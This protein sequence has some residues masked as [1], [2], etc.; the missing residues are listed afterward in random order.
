ML[1]Y[2]RYCELKSLYKALKA[3]ETMNVS[4]GDFLV[5][6]DEMPSVEIRTSD[7]KWM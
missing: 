7:C 1:I 5:D 2:G 3:G 4:Q 6:T